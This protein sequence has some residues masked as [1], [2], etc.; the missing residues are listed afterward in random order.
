MR[1]RG[2]ETCVGLRF[3]YAA[4]DA[5][6]TRLAV[7]SIGCGVRFLG[8]ASNGWRKV[9]RFATTREKLCISCDIDTDSRWK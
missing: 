6:E 3:I 2:L 5:F 1:H 7:D 4:S 9:S 8:F